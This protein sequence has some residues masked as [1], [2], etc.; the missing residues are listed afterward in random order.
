MT[1]NLTGVES[2]PEWD[3]KRHVTGLHSAV[4]SLAVA[5]EILLFHAAMAADDL[6]ECSDLAGVRAG[7][8]Q[9]LNELEHL[10]VEEDAEL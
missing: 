7:V 4:T 3:A 1:L 9:V 2:A 8:I 5:V 6:K 10:Y